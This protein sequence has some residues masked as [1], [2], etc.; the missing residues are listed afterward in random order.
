MDHSLIMIEYTHDQ[1]ANIGKARSKRMRELFGPD[2]AELPQWLKRPVWVERCV[3]CGSPKSDKRMSCCGEV[4]FK[5]EPEC[6]MC[7][8]DVDVCN[9]TAYGIES[10][11]YRCVDCNWASDPE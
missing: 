4:H 9:V 10:T 3:Y 2:P 7:G 8:C 5:E 6:P 1:L 11:V